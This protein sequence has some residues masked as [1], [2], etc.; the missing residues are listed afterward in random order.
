MGDASKR[1][2]GA[3]RQVVCVPV[4][5]A[6]CD[7]RSNTRQVIRLLSIV[8]ILHVFIRPNIAIKVQNGSA[9]NK[10]IVIAVLYL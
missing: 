10:L 3:V 9:Q 5:A 7:T 1:E 8:D 6:H 2:L 4:V